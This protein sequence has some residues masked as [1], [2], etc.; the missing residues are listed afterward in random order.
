MLENGF[1]LLNSHQFDI[2]Q[3][4]ND[5]KIDWGIV[6]HIEQHDSSYI[7]TIGEFLC[8]IALMR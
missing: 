5:L 7:L 4:L 8:A 6:G 3:L 1:V 2:L